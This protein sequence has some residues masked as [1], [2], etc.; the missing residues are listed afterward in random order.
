MSTAT[1][2]IIGPTLGMI[3]AFAVL[4]G[5]LPLLGRVLDAR[6]H[7]H[8]ILTPDEPVRAPI[9]GWHVPTGR[10]T[11]PAYRPSRRARRHHTGA[12]RLAG[13]APGQRYAPTLNTTHIVRSHAA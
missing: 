6:S 3:G 12:H 11:R 8:I 10:V 2:G 7:P 13:L 9:R 1:A 4:V 5:S